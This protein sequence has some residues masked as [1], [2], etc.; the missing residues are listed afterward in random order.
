MLLVLT[1]KSVCA[2][3]GVRKVENS[4][5]KHY[6]NIQASMPDLYSVH[7]IYLLYHHHRSGRGWLVRDRV[8]KKCMVKCRFTSLELSAYFPIYIGSSHRFASCFT[9]TKKTCSIFDI[10][11]PLVCFC[12]IHKKISCSSA[13][14]VVVR[15]WEVSWTMLEML[16]CNK[17]F[18]FL[19]DF[20]DMLVLL[21]FSFEILK[22]K[23]VSCD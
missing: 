14:R 15:T 22:L 1:E 13:I 9:A 3:E 23:F 17:D 21:C 11:V 7:C 18:L 19:C 20:T 2:D 6:L 10:Y 8:N 4:K 5:Q 16:K 12:T